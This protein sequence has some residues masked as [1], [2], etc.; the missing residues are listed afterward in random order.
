MLQQGASYQL[1]YNDEIKGSIA[2]KQW[3]CVIIFSMYFLGVD[4]CADFCPN[5]ILNSVLKRV[6]LL[7]FTFDMTD[8]HDDILYCEARDYACICTLLSA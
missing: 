8:V 6:F 3:T 5:V 2:L 4:D 7:R 1:I